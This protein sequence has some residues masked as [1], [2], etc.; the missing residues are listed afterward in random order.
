LIINPCSDP[1]TSCAFPAYF[2]LYTVYD[3]ISIIRH[4]LLLLLQQNLAMTGQIHMTQDQ[5]SR[6]VGKLFMER[7]SINLESDILDTPDF[8]WENDMWADVYE[9]VCEV[10]WSF[11]WA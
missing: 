7:N 2:E 8:L 10:R 6:E 1:T 11:A 3:N 5:I 9:K 4:G